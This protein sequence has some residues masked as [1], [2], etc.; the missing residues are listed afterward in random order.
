MD[1][2][3]KKNIVN[4]FIFFCDLSHISEKNS[5]ILYTSSMLIKEHFSQLN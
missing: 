3:Q 5:I 2:L 1:H 4:D